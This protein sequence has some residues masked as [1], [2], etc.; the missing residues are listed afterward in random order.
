[1]IQKYVFIVSFPPC[2]N[3]IYSILLHSF[4]VVEPNIDKSCGFS[5]LPSNQSQYIV[6][7]VLNLV[8]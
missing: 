5:L 1:M 8:Y 7:T 2:T 6:I 3:I 4:W